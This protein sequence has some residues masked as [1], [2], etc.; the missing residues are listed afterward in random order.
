MEHRPTP[1]SISWM[2]LEQPK[3]D[4]EKLTEKHN[5]RMGLYIESNRA[6]K[7]QG[8]S[9]FAIQLMVLPTGLDRGKQFKRGGLTAPS[10]KRSQ[11]PANHVHGPMGKGLIEFAVYQFLWFST[12]WYQQRTGWLIC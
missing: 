11:Q 9:D 1:M 6:E 5:N 8:G 4:C 2:M 12:G 7:Q 3:S 10:L